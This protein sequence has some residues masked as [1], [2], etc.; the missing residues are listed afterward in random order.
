MGELR[1]MGLTQTDLAR[2]LGKDPRSISRTL[3]RPLIDSRSDWTRILE[4]LDLEIIVT[5]RP[6][7]TDGG[8]TVRRGTHETNHA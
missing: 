1:R 5:V 8:E 4:A 7:A 3:A 6:K 2:M